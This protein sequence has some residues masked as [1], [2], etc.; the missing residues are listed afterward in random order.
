MTLFVADSIPSRAEARARISAL[1]AEIL[2]LEL[3]IISL[4]HEREAIK[5]QLDSYKYPVL[6]LPNEIVSEIFTHFVPVY[7]ISPPVV[8]ILSPSTLGQ[9]CRRWREIAL[10]TPSLWR[11]ISLDL[12]DKTAINH[13]TQ[14]HL[15]ETWLDHSRASPLSVALDNSTSLN[16]A[17]IL[18]IIDAALAHTSRWE[19]IDLWLPFSYMVLF[20]SKPMPLLRTLAFGPSTECPNRNDGIVL[21]DQAPNLTTVTLY[22]YFDPF[23]LALPWSQITTLRGMCLLED[24]LMEILRCVD[25]LVNCNVTL[26]HCVGSDNL[27]TIAPL[28]HLQNLTLTVEC[29]PY[30]AEMC[31]FDKLLLPALRSLQI[32]EP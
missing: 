18:R 4:R 8:G 19:E 26:V 3:Y 22:P 6:E 27:P 9:V 23:T 5:M 1:D 10:S 32:P 15:L 20:S 25:N 14:L 29:D 2:H 11:A 17:V 7:P 30:T 21:F 16:D 28:M 13:A 12:D 31:I 24:E